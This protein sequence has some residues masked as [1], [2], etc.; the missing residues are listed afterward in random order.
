MGGDG[1]IRVIQEHFERLYREDFTP[2]TE[3]G[4]E[5]AIPTLTDRLLKE[6]PEPRL[7]DIGC[8]NGWVSVYFGQRGIRVE[9]IDSSPTAIA[10]AEVR[11]AD[12]GVAD[13]VTFRL[14]NGLDLPYP[15]AAFNVVF[16]R[17]FFHHVP[18]RQ[19]RQYRREVRRVLKPHGWLSLHAFSTKSP[20]GIG[21]RF[22]REDIER[23]F[24]DPFALEEYTEDPW[25][26]SAPAH[27]NHF[28]FRKV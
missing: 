2:W 18:E 28:L 27:L 20:R 11:A 7:L 22:E 1:E 15:D 24:G 10:E 13:R 23:V 26:T 8:G 21:H 6:T 25:P 12:A 16:D 17:G 4:M 14:G 9:G 5:P 3:H 19:Y